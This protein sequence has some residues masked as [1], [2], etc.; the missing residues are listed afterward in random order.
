MMINIVIVVILLIVVLWLLFRR[1]LNIEGNTDSTTDSATDS[2]TDSATGSTTDSA[3]GS[4][5]DS[6]TGSTTDSTS[7][8][9]P[10]YGGWNL[11]LKQTY[12]ENKDSG[13]QPNTSLHKT[14][15]SQAN[16]F[17]K[18]L[19]MEEFNDLLHYKIVYET[20]NS[21]DATVI[22][23]S[24]EKIT[25]DTISNP[26]DG[27]TGLMNGNNSIGLFTDNNSEPNTKIGTYDKIQPTVQGEPVTMVKLYVWT[28]RPES[29]LTSN[30]M[31]FESWN[32]P[33]VNMKGQY[34]YNKTTGGI[35]QGS[36]TEDVYSYCFGKLKCSDGTIPVEPAVGEAYPAYCGDDNPVYCAGSALY[37]VSNNTGSVNIM[38]KNNNTLSFDLM[39]QYVNTTDTTSSAYTPDYYNK[40]RGLTVPS[41]DVSSVS[42][43]DNTIQYVKDGN[44]YNFHICDV[45][46][47]KGQG[48]D[49]NTSVKQACLDVFPITAPKNEF[50]TVEKKCIA[51]RGDPLHDTTYIDYVC[52]PGETCTGYKCGTQFGVCKPTAECG[53][54]TNYQT[55]E[56]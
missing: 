7:E 33:K 28:P 1:R 49:M 18:D 44:T 24:Q 8:P 26:S 42:L 56:D 5:T 23:W 29:L 47:N 15:L 54:Q 55:L 4:T 30:I 27:F 21:T 45:F 38:D 25:D 17:N 40:F 52:G 12:D 51:N 22:E 2:T 16:Y 35:D 14:D 32:I 37:T 36:D 3:T 19:V 11:Y 50:G 6:A 9:L 13:F 53:G 31:D 48:Y 20:S 10:S 39:G 46:D 43:E 34:Y 41:T